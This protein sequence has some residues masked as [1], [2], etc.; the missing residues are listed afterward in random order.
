MSRKESQTQQEKSKILKDWSEVYG[1]N[2]HN[3]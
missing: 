3:R 2:T 1:T